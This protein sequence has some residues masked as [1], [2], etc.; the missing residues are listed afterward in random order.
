MNDSTETPSNDAREELNANIAALKAAGEALVGAD[1]ID[2]P[3]W[4][5]GDRVQIKN[6]WHF[7]SKDK[8]G[9]E[10]MPA[11]T[12]GT[13]KKASTYEVF[14]LWDNGMSDFFDNDDVVRV[15]DA[16]V[17]A[18][19]ASPAPSGHA[20]E[21]EATREIKLKGRWVIN[22]LIQDLDEG[23]TVADI[24]LENALNY[25]WE[26]VNLTI[27]SDSESIVTGAWRVHHFRVV[28]LKRWTV[29]LDE[30]APAASAAVELETQEL[31]SIPQD[32]EAG[33]DEA[34]PVDAVQEE[35]KVIV[36]KEHNIALFLTA[37]EVAIRTTDAQA[38][39]GGSMS[40]DEYMTR[41][42]DRMHTILNDGMERVREKWADWRPMGFGEVA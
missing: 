37:P 17:V 42:D 12:Q 4:S 11:G 34:A 9:T 30:Q 31:E 2:V 27:T 28:T 1:A 19:P 24:D 21:G 33:V 14:V 23:P 15:V 18:A 6:L 7:Y 41:F 13:V 38:L 8:D 20:S 10:V 29:E 35:V 25:G 26:I 3:E 32:D 36:P 5:V 16:P 22:T 40:A 39:L